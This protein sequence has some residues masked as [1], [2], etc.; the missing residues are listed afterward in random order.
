MYV[1]INEFWGVFY[2][3]AGLRLVLAGNMLVAAIFLL[4]LIFPITATANK[5][6]TEYASQQSASFAEKKFENEKC[7]GCEQTLLDVSDAALQPLAR[8]I[9]AKKST[10]QSQQ[11]A[12]AKIDGKIEGQ[13]ATEKISVIVEAVDQKAVLEA[14]AIVLQSGGKVAF[15]GTVGNVV[16]A[17]VP[18][19]MLEKIASHP[20]IKGVFADEEVSV[21]L[22]EALPQIGVP[23]GQELPF[24]GK[25]VRVAVI[26]TGVESTHS[27]LAGRVVAEA[28]FS[29]DGTA[30]DLHGHG[31]H[32]AG[33]IAG[34]TISGGIFRGV[35][36]ESQIINAKALSKSG[37][38]KISSIINAVN[39]AINP[40]GNIFT[41]DGARIINLSFGTAQ[42]DENSPLES[43]IRAAE[44]LGVAVVV[45]AG[46]CGIEAPSP[47][48]NGFTGVTFPGRVKE[49]IT[50]GSVDGN[51]SIA[52]FSSHGNIN[53]YGLKP[54]LVAPGTGIAS[55]W[56]GNTVL[57]QSGT[58]MSAAFVSGVAALMIEKNPLLSPQEIKNILAKSAKDLGLEGP[59]DLYGFGLVDANLALNEIDLVQSGTI[60]KT[61]DSTSAKIGIED[62]PFKTTIKL[63]NRGNETAIIRY[64][65]ADKWLTAGFPREIPAG[66]ASYITL[67]A[68]QAQLGIGWHETDLMLAIDDYILMHRV[69][70]DVIEGK[71]GDASLDQEF[72]IEISRPGVIL[73]DGLGE[74]NKI[75]RGKTLA[76]TAKYSPVVF[77]SGGNYYGNLLIEGPSSYSCDTAL[78]SY[79]QPGSTG[80]QAHFTYTVPTNAPLGGY[81]IKSYSWEEC[82]GQQ[83]TGTCYPSSS[84]SCKTPSYINLYTVQQAFTVV[85]GCGEGICCNTQNGT[86]KGTGAICAQNKGQEYYCDGKKGG[87]LKKRAMNQ[88]CSG[89]SAACEGTEKWGGYEQVVK[90][91]PSQL[92]DAS[93]GACVDDPVTCYSDSDCG[94][95][96]WIGQ[97]A[98][99]SENFGGDVMQDHVTN[100]CLN[101]GTLQS[102]CAPQITEKMAK[103]DCSEKQK[104]VQDDTGSVACITPDKDSCTDAELGKSWCNSNATVETCYFDSNTRSNK[105][106]FESCSIGVCADNGA[107]FAHCNSA[108]SQF[109]IQ[110]EESALGIPVYKQPGDKLKVDF[111]SNQS[112][113]ISITINY[114]ENAFQSISPECASGSAKTISKG[115]NY[116]DY[117]VNESAA[118]RPYVFLALRGNSSASRLI[119]VS[120]PM[121]LIIT[122]SQKLAQRY[123][124]ESGAEPKVKSLMQKIYLKAYENQGVVYNLKDY[125]EEIGTQHPFNTFSGYG[126]RLDKATIWPV[127]DYVTAVANFVKSRCPIEYCKHVL[128]VGDD[129]V[130][131]LWRDVS[132]GQVVFSDSVYASTGKSGSRASLLPKM[133]SSGGFDSDG[134]GWSDEEEI[135]IHTNPN[136]K[137]DNFCEKLPSLGKL[138]DGT[139]E[140]QYWVDMFNRVALGRDQFSSQSADYLP[141]AARGLLAGIYY[142]VTGG[143]NSDVELAGVIIHVLINIDSYIEAIRFMIDYFVNQLP[144]QCS[145]IKN[146]A[147]AAGGMPS[148]YLNEVVPSIYADAKSNFPGKNPGWDE[149]DENVFSDAY[150][151]GYHIGYIAEQIAVAKGAGR[152]LKAGDAMKGL[153]TGH[154]AKNAGKE[155][156]KEAGKRTIGEAA[157]KL[158]SD[159]KNLSNAGYAKLIKAINE[160]EKG[161]RILADYRKIKG[162]EALKQLMEGDSIVKKI[163]ENILAKTPDNQ[164]GDMFIEVKTLEKGDPIIKKPNG[165]VI[166]NAIGDELDDGLKQL[167]NINGEK[168]IDI[169]TRNRTIQVTMDELTNSE[170][171]LKWWY[172]FSNSQTKRIDE[173]WLIVKDNGADK[174]IRVFEENGVVK[175]SEIL[176]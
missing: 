128:I 175:H 21:S 148:T 132:L 168:I 16:S 77:S 129:Y 44:A 155:A 70:L 112:V 69:K 60:V 11:V 116:C 5:F 105:K 98:C 123:S 91:P 174:I 171:G 33:I 151:A 67:S 43:A 103:N 6:S 150:F 25:R 58:S 80:T 68:N 115:E 166:E 141:A 31:T 52:G 101:K 130:M 30:V 4:L 50:I 88:Y 111:H 17:K 87:T 134:D 149:K 71:A 54:D 35:A 23:S 27:M 136:N 83:Y 156:L 3:V 161:E 12:R 124:R 145:I 137:N 8:S 82:T 64:Y 104:C 85:A 26:D 173:I 65:A 76:L 7:F 162:N 78:K 42:I 131:P 59:D 167:D 93:A 20:Q 29:G 34:T 14:A 37:R 24:S 55:S 140:I 146:G 143:V 126:E 153:E 56:I 47:S 66:E 63:Y 164:L 172:T 75:A 79:Y 10:L 96:G 81:S 38:G 118:K 19:D 73:I 49:A 57:A 62:E 120:M 139:L 41:G 1:V 18:R 114:D 94:P 36:P 48:C 46:N 125:R 147:N 40:D 86:F 45:S 159:F 138:L 97:I 109:Q 127:N 51:N 170:N 92:C 122:D 133:N 108:Q 39:Y 119:N 89:A 144:M 160:L 22:S 176:R 106:K 13:A 169:D 113:D 95:T 28:D 53:G 158:L 152:V 15:A 157:S 135:W 107:G 154:M 110:I 165:R 117:I 9:C 142:G 163:P 74:G 90:C 61:L 2:G 32:V 99:S 121:T 102:T 84:Y 72:E 100:T